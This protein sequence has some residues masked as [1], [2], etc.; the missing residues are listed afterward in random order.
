MPELPEAETIARSLRPSLAGRTIVSAAFLAK[1][2]SSD[3]PARLA[4]RPIRGVER[5]GKQL[6]IALDS[7]FI[8]VKLG[9]TGALLMN[10]EPGLHK[11]VFTPRASLTG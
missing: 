2:V 5:Y 7:G 3:D 1:R 11:P 6:L 8:H 4:G 10:R 9:M